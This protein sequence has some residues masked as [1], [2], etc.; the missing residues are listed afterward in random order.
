MTPRILAALLVFSMLSCWSPA[1]Q[2]P[3][4]IYYNGNIYT[5]DPLQ[6]GAQ[7][8]A[9]EDGR[10]IAIGGDE[11]ILVLAEPSTKLVNLQGRFVMPGFIDGHAHL[12]GVGE[13]QQ[14]VQLL[15]TRSWSEVLDQVAE[16]VD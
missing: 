3:D 4:A 14:Q 13:M 12:V 8:M 5:V 1:D 16:F 10:I 15:D 11:E 6:P 9:I 7:A 2:G